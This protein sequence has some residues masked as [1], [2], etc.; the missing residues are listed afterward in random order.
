M[1]GSSESGTDG[2]SVLTASASML[3]ILYIND[4]RFFARNG[5]RPVS[6][7]NITVPSE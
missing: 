1:I 3:M 5:W 2:F 6:S 7:S 4:A